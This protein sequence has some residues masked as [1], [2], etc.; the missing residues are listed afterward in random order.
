MIPCGKS[1]RERDGR[2]AVGLVWH[3]RASVAPSRPHIVRIATGIVPAWLVL[4]SMLKGDLCQLNGLH[5]YCSAPLTGDP[6]IFGLLLDS[7]TGR[8]RSGPFSTAA[9]GTWIAI[10]HSWT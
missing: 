4:L 10:E 9:I 7:S 1:V 5:T 6:A 2:C 8:A 3:F